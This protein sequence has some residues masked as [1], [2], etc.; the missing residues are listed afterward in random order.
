MFA[1]T[2]STSW[3]W[4]DSYSGIHSL[5]GL[6]CQLPNLYVQLARGFV[7]GEVVR[8][9]CWVLMEK[10]NGGYWYKQP[11]LS[12]IHCSVE[13]QVFIYFA[14]PHH[15]HFKSPCQRFF[16]LSPPFCFFSFC[17]LPY[18]LAVLSPTS[19]RSSSL[20]PCRPLP[21]SRS[22]GAHHFTPLLSY[23]G[24]ILFSSCTCPF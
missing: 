24:A 11:S 4:L 17:P 18:L 8:N 10:R 22:P 5:F 19:W 13:L 16:L 20:P 14:L 23:C 1:C 21:C 12:L 15:P 2:Y 7:M 9:L 6:L 3:Q